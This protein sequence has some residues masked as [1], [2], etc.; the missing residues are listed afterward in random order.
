MGKHLG[1]VHFHLLIRSAK[2]LDT[3]N[4]T[5]LWKE[6]RFGG[7]QTVGPSGEVRVYDENLSAA[8]YMFKHLHDPSWD[9]SQWRLAGAS[10]RMPRSFATSKETR[11]MWRRQQERVQRYAA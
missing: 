2:P 1:R 4:F 9:W 11:R 7:D 5:E 6:D 8:F 3:V 10:K